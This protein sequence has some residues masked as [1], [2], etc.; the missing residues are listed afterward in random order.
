MSVAT[1]SS[2]KERAMSKKTETEILEEAL[3]KGAKRVRP[4]PGSDVE[5]PKEDDVAAPRHEHAVIHKPQT[6]A[7]NIVP[8]GFPMK[9]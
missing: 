3:K 1:F 2:L 9:P 4:E 8:G 5:A 7:P 6:E